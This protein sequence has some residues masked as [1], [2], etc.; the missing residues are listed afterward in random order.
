VH[1]GI[2][3]VTSPVTVLRYVTGVYLKTP[4]RNPVTGAEGEL[5][6][7]NSARQR[8]RVTL[9]AAIFF[10]SSFE[11][12]RAVWDVMD[13]NA[14][15]DMCSEWP[16][17]KADDVKGAFKTGTCVGYVWG[18]AGAL[19]NASMVCLKGVQQNQLVDVIKRWLDEHPEVRHRSA[20]ALIG[21]ALMEKFPCQ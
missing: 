10:I 4:V 19:G 14:L 2:V 9:I 5:T 8:W 13:G 21:Q 12:A 18:A 3:T 1:Y 16:H 15:F 6:M 20:S 7:D 17:G 11:D